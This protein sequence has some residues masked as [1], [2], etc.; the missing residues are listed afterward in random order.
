M[1]IVENLLKVKSIVTLAL[2]IG[3]I[4]MLTGVFQ[5]PEAVFEAYKMD[6]V[7]VITYFFTKRDTKTEG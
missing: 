7:S 2:T 5:P 6:Y 4:L 3:I 1:K